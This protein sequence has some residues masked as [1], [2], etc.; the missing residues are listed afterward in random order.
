MHQARRALLLT[1]TALTLTTAL[2]L[3][4]NGKE[5]TPGDLATAAAH[6]V[7]GA[8]AVLQRSTENARQVASASIQGCYTAPAGTTLR[9]RLDDHIEFQLHSQEGGA[10]QNGAMHTQAEL[11]TTVLARRDEEV[12]ARLDLTAV[13][14][15]GPDGNEVPADAVTHSFTA[16]AATPVHLRVRTDGTV[17]GLQFADG[18]DG[19]QR[20][21]LRGTLLLATFPAPTTD[22]VRW[23]SH[24]A[25]T[26]GE[27]AAR[28]TRL[29]AAAGEVAVQREKLRYLRM[30]AHDQVPQHELRG[31]ATGTFRLELGW[32]ATVT[33]DE[34]LTTALPVLDL[35]AITRRRSTIE[36]VGTD[37]TRI[38]HDV[39]ALWSGTTV[40]VAGDRE[41][42]GGHA[43][44][45][46]RSLWQ[47]RLQGVTLATLLDRLREILGHEPLD[48]E[49]LDGAFQQMQ[50]L[51][52]F[53]DQVATALGQ[54]VGTRQLTGAIAATA[55]SAL[56]AAGT[57][58]AQQTLAAVRADR[59][60]DFDVRETATVSLLQLPA[61]APKLMA[62]LA[63]D[64]D[65]EFDGQQ[66]AML[67][68]GALAERAARLADGR[69]VAT[70]LLAMERAAA[71]RNDLP[72]WLLAVGNMASAEVLGPASRYLDHADAA[73]RGAA[74]TALRRVPEAAAATLL[75][76]RGLTDADPFVR[77][78][79]V[80]AL[81]H[82]QEAAAAAALRQAATDDADPATR[83]TALRELARAATP[84]SDHRATI[85]RAAATDRDETVRAFARELLQR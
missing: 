33:L 69:S 44:A 65:V 66:G 16:A 42:I 61:P 37:M 10:A 80:R 46:E 82:R 27:F 63:A 76:D 52:R 60:L 81:G 73:V 18:L 51:V 50:W 24:G 2:W 21:F 72:T 68:L 45:A 23:E 49:A 3:S 30:A 58:A 14:F 77:Q 59:T 7:L 53:D 4:G 15:L 47:Q 70:T 43:E 67:V 28:C 83:R 35:R 6:T 56:G 62:G 71:Q 74:F 54:M 48:A 36:L 38:D 57:E 85:E 12:L 41:S 25:D 17:L 79:A 39:A 29:L 11:T 5:Q 75:V 32:L 13:R 22:A 34:H 40:D 78:E 1:C 8:D 55:L 20:N 19:D 31:L 84:G 64:A 9:Y 26:T